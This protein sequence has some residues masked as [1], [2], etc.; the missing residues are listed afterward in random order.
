[1][2]RPIAHIIKADVILLTLAQY[3]VKIN[4]MKSMVFSYPILLKLILINKDLVI[5]SN[6]ALI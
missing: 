5:W 2:E 3:K 6:Y 1:M 4:K